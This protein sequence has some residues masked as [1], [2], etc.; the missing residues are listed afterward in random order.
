M[1]FVHTTNFI[2][3]N[4]NFIFKYVFILILEDNGT[5][6]TFFK[7]RRR[8]ATLSRKSKKYLRLQQTKKKSPKNLQHKR[9]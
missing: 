9:K 6:I 8:N 2:L 1:F 4:E 7:T 5:S 3:K